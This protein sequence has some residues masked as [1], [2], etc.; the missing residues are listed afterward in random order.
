MTTTA[1][2]FVALDLISDVNL[3]GLESFWRGSISG[4]WAWLEVSLP[5]GAVRCTLKDTADCLRR[6]FPGA[7]VKRVCIAKVVRV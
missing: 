6:D 2:P 5:T 3:R 1:V 7:K 4:K